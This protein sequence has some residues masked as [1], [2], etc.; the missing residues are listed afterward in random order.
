LLN[1]ETVFLLSIY[2]KGEKDSISDKEV[3]QL[4]IDVPKGE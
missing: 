4:L 3:Q 1:N 2:D